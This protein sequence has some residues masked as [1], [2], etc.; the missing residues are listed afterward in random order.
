M[1]ESIVN[2]PDNGPPDQFD[3]PFPS[4]CLD[5][6]MVE[7]RIRI[8][9]RRN[10]KCVTPSREVDLIEP[11]SH[12]LSLMGPVCEDLARV[13]F[14]IVHVQGSGVDLHQRTNNRFPGELVDNLPIRP[15]IGVQAGAVRWEDY[16]EVDI[17]VRPVI[18]VDDIFN[19]HQRPVIHNIPIQDLDRSAGRVDGR[20]LRLED[21][22]IVDQFGFQTRYPPQPIFCCGSLGHNPTGSPGFDHY[23][24][25]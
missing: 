17:L 4:T 13:R 6:K 5:G 20:T 16:P 18:P 19:K 22:D 23:R 25:T 15:T 24:C 1:V 8:P 21:Q 14:E 10:P 12:I 9:A 2:V 11:V 7:F 3:I